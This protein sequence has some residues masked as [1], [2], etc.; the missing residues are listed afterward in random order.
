MTCEETQSSISL[1]VDGA[2]PAADEPDMFNH[3]GNCPECR[4]FMK[5]ALYVRTT[6]AGS[7]GLTAP[8]SLKERILR[9][10]V[11][12]PAARWGIPSIRIAMPLSGALSLSVIVIIFTLLFSPIFLDDNSSAPS[13]AA[14][15]SAANRTLSE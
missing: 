3:I 1:F 15:R 6:V 8:A 10:T 11:R 5:D 12:P 2:L 14:V 7:I 9:A 13:A 4:T